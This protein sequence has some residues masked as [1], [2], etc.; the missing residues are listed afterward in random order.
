MVK[1]AAKTVKAYLAELPKEKRDVISA[2]RKMVLDHLPKGYQEAMGFGMINYQIPLERYPDTY[3]GQPL[4][5]V[6]LAAQKHY[7][8]LYLMSVY[9]DPRQEAALVKG[10]KQAGKRLDMG[11]SC[12]RF[13]S[14]DDLPM[15]V[16]GRAIAAMPPSALIE[17][18]ESVKRKR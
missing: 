14:L 6:A 17:R 9:A 3:N 8:S 11:K 2:V 5:A 18:Y 15:D 16:L 1:S 12:V 13:K 4:M 10:F 7:F